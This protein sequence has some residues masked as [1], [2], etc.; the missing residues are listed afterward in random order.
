MKLTKEIVLGYKLSL[1]LVVALVLAKGAVAD[2]IQLQKSDVA[3]AI[4]SFAT[5]MVDTSYGW[6][7]PVNGKGAAPRSDA[8]YEVN[9][10]TLVTPYDA[11]SSTRWVFAGRSLVIN[12]GT[13]YPQTAKTASLEFADLI[14]KGNSTLNNGGWSHDNSIYGKITLDS[15][16]TLTASSGGTGHIWYFKNEF[17]AANDAVLT[18]TGASAWLTNGKSAAVRM[19]GNC[20]NFCGTVKGDLK[21]TVSLNCAGGRFPGKVEVNRQSTFTIVSS[22]SSK[23]FEVGV[24]KVGNDSYVTIPSGRTVAI[25][26]LNFSGTGTKLDVK[27]SGVLIVTNSLAVTSPVVVNPPGMP[28]AAIMSVP[29]ALGEIDESK[30]VLPDDVDPYRCR[31]EWKPEGDMQTLYMTDKACGTYDATTG[32]MPQTGDESSVN[33]VPPY[34]FFEAGHWKDTAHV[35]NSTTNYYTV[36]T[37]IVPNDTSRT[38]A[39]GASLTLAGKLRTLNNNKWCT[40]GDLIVLPASAFNSSGSYGNYLYAGKM[41]VLTTVDQPLQFLGGADN[42]GLHQKFVIDMT[43]YGSSR[44]AMELIR[45]SAPGSA[46]PTVDF[47]GDCTGYY[48]SIFVNT[49][50][51]LRL[52]NTGLPNG[53]VELWTSYS[54][55]TTLATN[56]ADVAVGTLRTTWPTTV[57]VPA[58]NTLSVGALDVVGTLAKNGAGVLCAGGTATAGESA[59]ISVNAGGVRAESKD[60]FNGIPLSFAA[61]TSLTLPLAT[62]DADFAKY[63]LYDSAAVTAASTLNVILDATGV[64]E[65]PTISRGVLTVPTS[66][67][68]GLLEKLTASSPWKGYRVFFDSAAEGDMTIFTATIQKTGFTVIFR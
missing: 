22:S 35:P 15:G 54:A 51:T 37:L 44:A 50:E 64:E 66:A 11:S 48:G 60:A 2:Y 29:L 26:D 62:S 33:N 49:N 18:C 63:G 68:S 21:I 56:N 6:D 28:K 32:Y 41:E 36:K 30:F 57:E 47:I 24:V 8:D 34:A 7:D 10:K 46:S 3:S 9:A 1:G 12:N 38:F 25:G 5:N 67:A 14:F 61:G 59:A 45:A 13:L 23:S 4:S 31:L 53:T 40:F 42:G 39:G 27:K 52:G 20:S 43:V 58:T 19:D 16:T 55:L 65:A 17:A